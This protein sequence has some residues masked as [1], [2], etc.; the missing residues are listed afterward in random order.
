MLWTLLHRHASAMDVGAD[1]A[2]TIRR[3]LAPVGRNGVE[4]LLGV[5]ADESDQRLPK[6][7]RA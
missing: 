1:K 2:P 6:V 7:A 4:Q 5:A 3:S